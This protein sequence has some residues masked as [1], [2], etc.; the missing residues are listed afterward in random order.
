[1]SANKKNTG[2][3]NTGSSN[4]GHRN[5][6]DYNAGDYN[7]GHWNAGNSNTGFFNTTTP[8]KVNIFDVMNEKAEWD[9]CD[10]PSFIYFNLTEWIVSQDMTDEE[11]SENESHVNTGGYLKKND[12]KAEF[13]RSY[14]KASKEDQAKIFNIPNFDADKFFEISGIDVRI[15]TEVEDKKAELIAKAEELLEQA[16]NM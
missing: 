1:M 14:T 2:H 6:G 16:R 3:S 5:A 11:K 10:K 9:A 7:A 8:S 13:Q 4:A 15:N 12:Y